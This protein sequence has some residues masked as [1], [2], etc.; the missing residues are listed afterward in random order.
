MLELRKFDDADYQCY[1]YVEDFCNE[2]VP[3]IAKVRM[4]QPDSAGRFA[5]V[6]V[7]GNGIQIMTYNED[8]KR[9]MVFLR[10]LYPF[11]LAVFVAQHLEEPLKPEV[12]ASFG[13]ER[14]K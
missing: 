3:L 13:F 8:G 11:P 9:R 4:A 12:L 14:I 1:P 7:D 5:T 2:I 10:K 6:I